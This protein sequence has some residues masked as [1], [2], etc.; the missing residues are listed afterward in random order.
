MR[1]IVDAGP[2]IALSKIGHLNLLPKL[3]DK[4][5]V[6]AEV[7]REVAPPGETRPGAEIAQQAWALQRSADPDARRALQ[8]QHRLHDGEAEA[9]LL[10]K[11]DPNHSVLLIDEERGIRVALRL[12]L[13]LLRVGALLVRGVETHHL[14]AEE[15]VRALATL[16][17]ER[18]LDQQAEREILATLRVVKTGGK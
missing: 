10:A 9:I 12:K 17:H 16:R 1:L 3:F 11:E 18:Y 7:V 8:V 2:L 14:A 6:P 13:H 4:I 15:V 5:I